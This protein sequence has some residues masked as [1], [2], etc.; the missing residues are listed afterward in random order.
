MICAT[1]ARTRHR[2]MVAEYQ[3]AA[4]QGADLVELR[5]DFLRRPA[6]LGRL[7]ERRPCPVIA[8][9]RRPQD[10]GRFK[11]P[12]EKRQ[13]ILRSAIAAAVD[14]VDLESDIAGQIPR[15]GKSKR[16]V[17]YHN[18]QTTPQNLEAI[19]SQ[20]IA[21]D[22]DIIKIVTMA[23]GPSDNV[24]MLQL[25]QKSSVPMVGFCMGD[26]GIASRVLAAKYGAPFVYAAFNKERILAPGQLTFEELRDVYRLDS[27]KPDSEVFAVIGDPVAQSLSPHVHNRAFL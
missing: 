8:T 14:Y 22:P 13:L 3:A 17:S 5:L 7:L 27:I 4:E 25:V 20:M 10:G 24:R 11:E 19:H 18:F 23:E 9:C 12:E 2:M 16:I 21:L 15:F 1:I 26:M 6:D